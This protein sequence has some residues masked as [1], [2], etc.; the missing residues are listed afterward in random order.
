MQ[1][2][3]EAAL[4]ALEAGVEEVLI[5]PGAKPEVVGLAVRLPAS[6]PGSCLSTKST[7]TTLSLRP[8]PNRGCRL[9]YTGRK[10]RAI[11]NSVKYLRERFLRILW[12]VPH[13][14]LNSFWRSSPNLGARTEFS[15]KALTIDVRQSSGTD[16][17]LARCFGRAAESFSPKGHVL[18]EEDVRLL[19]TEGTGS[20]LGDRARRGR[21][22]AKT[23]PSARLPRRWAADA[24]RSG[25][26]PAAA[27]ICLPRKTA[28]CW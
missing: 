16:F 8:T 4:R 10:V 14:D 28:A 19:E 26:R 12:N 13:Y 1:A 17:M 5:A 20:G 15:M 23:M 18:S 22:R 7:R 21:G 25:W 2:K 9:L 6:A 24:L 27:R 3:L 11:L